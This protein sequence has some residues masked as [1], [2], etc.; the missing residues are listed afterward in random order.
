MRRNHVAQK[1]TFAGLTA[2][3]YYVVTV[4]VAPISY[5]QIQ[6]RLSEVLLFLCLRNSFGVW[7]YTIG[8]MLA[9]LSSPL[10]IIDVVLG[11]G[12]NL[13][14]ALVARLTGRILPT[15][16]IVPLLGGLAVGTELWLCYGLPLVE[17]VL[18]VALGQLAALSIG[19]LLYRAI[20]QRI[21][22]YIDHFF[23]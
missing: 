11:G 10:G 23:M 5:G 13:V 18:A 2:A 9:N 22:R 15:L 17:S 3:L 1:I 19:A 8:C 7:G 20:G 16:L 12:C 14:C 21:Q 4:F 6:C